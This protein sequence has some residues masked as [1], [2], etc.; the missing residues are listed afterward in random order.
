MNTKIL[1]G[2]LAGGIFYFL[3]GWLV[4]GNLL[5]DMMPPPE[6]IVKPFVM[7][8]MVLSC[9]AW[10][11]LLAV[12]CARWANAKTFGSGAMVGAI[13][14]ALV[15]ASHNLGMYAIFN[16]TTINGLLID[17]GVNLVG[18]AI[19]GGVIGLILGMGNKS[20]V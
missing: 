4:Y 2:T 1:L 19:A 17:I 14:G 16:L 3:Y 9:L 6:S 7:W 20:N 11:L 5:A 13:V 12:I 15:S 8:A 18:S 10:A